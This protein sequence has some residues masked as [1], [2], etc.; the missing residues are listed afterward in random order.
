MPSRGKARVVRRVEGL[1]VD[2]V[3]PQHDEKIVRL[4]AHPHTP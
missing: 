4:A 3:R 1:V 2:N